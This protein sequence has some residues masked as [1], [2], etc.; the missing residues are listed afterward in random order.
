MC[1]FS[2]GGVHACMTAA[3]YP[4]PLAVVPLL[5]PRS[6]SS[7]FVH[8]A[9]REATAW[10]PLAEPVDESRRVRGAGGHAGHTLTGALVHVCRHR[11]RR[12]VSAPPGYAESAGR[13]G[14]QSLFYVP[15][16]GLSCCAGHRRGGAAG[17]AG[18]PAHGCSGARAARAAG[19]Q[20]GAQR[21]HGS[22]GTPER[23]PAGPC[24]PPRPP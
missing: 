7:A 19:R 16:T 13:N 4:G 1:G 2:M 6:A 5:A 10:R 21:P 9:L 24:S 18:Q 22:H 3:L 8:G 20:A 17:G 11:G 12:T 23:T 14:L 15:L